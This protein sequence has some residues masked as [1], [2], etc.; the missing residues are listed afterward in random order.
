MYV[1][2]SRILV[3]VINSLAYGHK[4][5]KGPSSQICIKSMLTHGEY[6]FYH[7]AIDS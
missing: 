5:L 1:P 7:M 2:Y 4:F 3:L 6:I